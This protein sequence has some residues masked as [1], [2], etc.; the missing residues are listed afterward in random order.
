[1]GWYPI[2][3]MLEFVMSAFRIR[4]GGVREGIEIL[5]ADRLRRWIVLEVWLY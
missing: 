1:M 2:L 3:L 5:V 4:E